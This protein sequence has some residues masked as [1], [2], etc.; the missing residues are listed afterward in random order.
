MSATRYHAEAFPV[1][2]RGTIIGGSTFNS[3][4]IDGTADS[5]QNSMHPRRLSTV[6]AQTELWQQN[7]PCNDKD[8]RCSL[9]G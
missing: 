6:S 7:Y 1:A 3:F 5:L 2:G 4:A 8:R 9:Q